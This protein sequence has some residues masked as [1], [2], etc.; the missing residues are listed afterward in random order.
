MTG[1]SSPL[2]P[3]K[4][5]SPVIHNFLSKDRLKDEIEY[6][7]D[8]EAREQLSTAGDKDIDDGSR[9]ENVIHLT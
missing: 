5:L 4:F 3:K 7:E 1:N 9:K 8:D 6:R 2:V